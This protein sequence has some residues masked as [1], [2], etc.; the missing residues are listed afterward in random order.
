[1]L[2]PKEVS[3]FDIDKKHNKANFAFFEMCQNIKPRKVAFIPS[4]SN[5]TVY[6]KLY[7]I[8]YAQFSNVKF[9]CN[10]KSTMQK[11]VNNNTI[12][13]CTLFCFENICLLA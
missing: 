3:K 1:M 7:L 9:F 12:V 5:V 4:C 13:H 10:D 6:N 2:G 11:Y 8:M